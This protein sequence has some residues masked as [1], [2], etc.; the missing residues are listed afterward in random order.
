M[1]Q[2]LASAF[3][4]QSIDW[5]PVGKGAQVMHSRGQPPGVQGGV[6]WSRRGNQKVMIIV[7]SKSIDFQPLF[8]LF[9]DYLSLGISLVISD[10]KNP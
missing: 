5:V 2:S 6:E 9:K 1:L 8:Y 10:W 4:W 3:Q 7:I